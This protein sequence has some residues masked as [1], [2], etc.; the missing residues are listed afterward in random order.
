MKFPSS[1]GFLFHTQSFI[2][3][4]WDVLS[5]VIVQVEI[6]FQPIKQLNKKLLAVFLFI[7]G[8]FIVPPKKGS[9]ES[10]GLQARL[11][12]DMHFLE[13]FSISSGN[14]PK[15]SKMISVIDVFEVLLAEKV[16]GERFAAGQT[17]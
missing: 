17:L 10:F 16:I 6:L 1:L 12:A 4:F 5:S 11:G 2:F 7:S 13:K 8:V 14:L 15:G 3:I 9:L